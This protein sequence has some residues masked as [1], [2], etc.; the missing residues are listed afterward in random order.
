MKY[1]KRY[2]KIVLTAEGMPDGVES[3]SQCKVMKNV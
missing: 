2:M 3:N 1:E